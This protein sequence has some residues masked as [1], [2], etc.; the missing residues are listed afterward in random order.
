MTMDEKNGNAP[1]DVSLVT[2]FA[3][4]AAVLLFEVRIAAAALEIGIK[5]LASWPMAWG[6]HA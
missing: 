3:G 5:T 2:E 1:L 6:R 4:S